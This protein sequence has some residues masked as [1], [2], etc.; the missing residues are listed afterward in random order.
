MYRVLVFPSSNEPGLE[1][2]QALS[3]S[4][5]VTLFGGSSYDRGFDPSRLLIQ[6]HLQCP[7]LSD[8]GFESG[9]RAL[10]A[11]HR[12]D[13][14]FP[15]VDKVVA[16]MAAWEV[17]RAAIV[18][19]RAEM[20]SLLLSKRR[21][22][23]RLA[24]VVPVPQVYDKG[25]EPELPAYAKPDVGAGGREALKLSSPE[26]VCIARQRNLLVQEF[27]PGEE[28]TVDCLGDLAGRLLFCN[29]RLRGVVNRGIALGTSSLEHP[30][31]E[32]HLRG[33]AREMA[34]AGPW[35]AQFKA[36]ADGTL[37]L[38]EVNARVAGSMT[39][40][41][42]AGVNIPLIALFLFTGHAIT[43]PRPL[44]G[45]RLNRFLRTVGEIADFDAVIWDLDDTIIRP[46]GKP[47]PEVLARIYDFRNQGKRQV[48]VSRNPD[49]E[50]VL[51][52]NLIPRAF[53]DVLVVED[54]VAALGPV[55]SELGI[56]PARCVMVNDSVSEG[57]EI[58]ETQPDLRVVMP[59][60]LDVLARELI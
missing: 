24:G 46:D 14:V 36:A 35:F 20:A 53:V 44:K 52:A 16:E 42:L 21:T 28:Y 6:R 27:L 12:I 9:M 32:S 43:V 3:K 34:I 25:A 4:N 47:D 7:A 2:L 5:K 60:A 26:D 56:P 22:Y 11:E 57:L 58:A 17:E 1:T 55:L 30:E 29:V 18:A 19:P 39:L 23:E 33:I 40:T 41:R 8:E 59:D 48:V 10:I 31:I 15:T 54:K 50:A 38:L 51:A 45:V 37:K 49:A 13:V